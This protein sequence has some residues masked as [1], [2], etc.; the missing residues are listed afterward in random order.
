[1]GN[2]SEHHHGC[3]CHL[4]IACAVCCNTLEGPFLQL[5]GLLHQLMCHT[6]CCVPVDCHPAPT[7]HHHRPALL[8]LHPSYHFLI[9]SNMKACAFT[10]VADR[11]AGAALGQRAAAEGRQGGRALQRVPAPHH[12]AGQAQICGY[13]FILLM[14]T[15]FAVLF[16]C[17]TLPN[18]LPQ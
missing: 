4:L 6:P 15:Q 1:M 12:C 7:L 11:G 14:R 8:C 3:S 9:T 13:L 5:W 2:C 10:N 17:L 16:S 18:I